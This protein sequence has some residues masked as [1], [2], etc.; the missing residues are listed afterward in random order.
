MDVDV[1]IFRDKFIVI[2]KGVA[3]SFLPESRFSTSRLL[4]GE[5]E[6]ADE[7]L[8]AGFKTLKIMT[9]PLY[10]KPNVTI[11]PQE[12]CEGGLCSV[13]RRVLLELGYSA[14]AKK[15]EIQL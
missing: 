1:Q 8:R 3:H 5:F 2:V 7:C 12:M 4:V 6:A 11:F 13:E 15:V 9:F 14:G 10:V